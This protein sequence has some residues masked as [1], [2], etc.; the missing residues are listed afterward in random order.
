MLCSEIKLGFSWE[1]EGVDSEY[2]PLILDI[3]E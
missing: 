1:D 2:S 3:E